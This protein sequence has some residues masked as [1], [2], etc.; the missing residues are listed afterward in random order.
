MANTHLNTLPSLLLSLSLSLFSLLSWFRFCL[1]PYPGSVTF[2]PCPLL[3]PPPFSYLFSSGVADSAQW[4]G[5]ESENQI[6]AKRD[7]RIS[8]TVQLQ[9][10]K[11]NNHPTGV[12]QKCSSPSQKCVSTHAKN[13]TKWR[14][15]NQKEPERDRS[16]KQPSLAASSSDGSNQRPQHPL[17]LP[18]WMWFSIP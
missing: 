12:G 1:P 14:K 5:A 11:N 9:A 7:W 16:P 8:W 10:A 3:A 18:L 6:D 2:A 17:R 4:L 13:R 15:N